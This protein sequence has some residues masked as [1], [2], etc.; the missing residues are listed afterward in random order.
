MFLVRGRGGLLRA[1][2]FILVHLNREVST[3]AAVSDRLDLLRRK[4]I[5]RLF[6]LGVLKDLCDVDKAVE[7]VENIRAGR[8]TL[9]DEFSLLLEVVLDACLPTICEK[10]TVLAENFLH[11][12]ILRLRNTAP[13]YIKV[14]LHLVFG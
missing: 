7:I 13:D 9:R 11:L 4:I 10:F 8:C 12:P 3:Q 2:V 5:M 14:H 1:R 6:L